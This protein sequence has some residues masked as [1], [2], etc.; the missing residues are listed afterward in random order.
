MASYDKDRPGAVVQMWHLISSPL[1]AYNISHDC[2][3]RPLALGRYL[4]QSG[5][6]RRM[7]WEGECQDFSNALMRT[8][9]P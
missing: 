7:S 6:M 1:G 3:D 2:L 9:S 8:Y 5:G 4:K